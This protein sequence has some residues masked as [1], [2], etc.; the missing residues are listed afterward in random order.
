MS[1]CRLNWKPSLVEDFGNPL[2]MVKVVEVPG[3]EP[4][5]KR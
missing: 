4:Y 1:G 3:F 5:L 2:T